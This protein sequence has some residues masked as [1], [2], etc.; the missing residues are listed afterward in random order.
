MTKPNKKSIKTKK[1]GKNSQTIA[2]F[3]R[4]KK[5]Q[6]EEVARA[7]NKDGEGVT[8]AGPSTVARVV[9]TTTL[10]KRPMEEA[11]GTE[12]VLPSPTP[13]VLPFPSI[14]QPQPESEKGEK[15]EEDLGTVS[16]S[17]ST[18]GSS[19]RSRKGNRVRGKKS[20]RSQ[21]SEQMEMMRFWM[22]RD[23]V[24]RKEIQELRQ[25]IETNSR[26]SQS[27]DNQRPA[28]NNEATVLTGIYKKEKAYHEASR[29]EYEA[30]S[31]IGTIFPAHWPLYQWPKD[32]FG[33]EMLTKALYALKHLQEQHLANHGEV[34]EIEGEVMDPEEKRKKGLRQA[35]K[36]ALRELITGLRTSQRSLLYS[37]WEII[38]PILEETVDHD[39][40]HE[41]KAWE[42]CLRGIKDIEVWIGDHLLA[43]R[44]V[45]PLVV[46]TG[47]DWQ[48]VTRGGKWPSQA[49]KGFRVGVHPTTTSAFQN[50]AKIAAKKAEDKKRADE[51]KLKGIL[52]SPA[53]KG[54]ET[55]KT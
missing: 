39:Y 29:G 31:L 3:L 12:G 23:D 37:E 16:S 52:P 1:T 4:K 24:H 43:C 28:S 18:S 25:L 41:H 7:A 20:H 42:I 54:K 55:G 6:Q 48:E 46:T 51:K 45:S 13:G 27:G 14:H 35:L 50:A 49:T 9:P 19:A 44:S 2:E 40:V 38:E 8:A 34:K 47:R 15:I 5:M 22:Q 26:S 21:S 33:K 17:A 53:D 32:W 30:S 36:G 11:T 10:L